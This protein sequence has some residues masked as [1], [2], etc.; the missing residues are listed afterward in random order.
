MLSILVVRRA[1]ITDPGAV[2]PGLERRMLSHVLAIPPLTNTG[3]GMFPPYTQSPLIGIRI[4]GGY[5]I[6]GNIP[7]HATPLGRRLETGC[8][9]DS[10]V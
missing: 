6:T 1:L 10:A 7:R 2:D 9:R 4:R 5:C 8:L 3:L